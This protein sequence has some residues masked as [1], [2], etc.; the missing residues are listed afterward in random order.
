MMEDYI[1]FSSSMMLLPMS[2]LGTHGYDA[3]RQQ[4]PFDTISVLSYLKSPLRRPTVIE[5]WAPLEIATFEAAM[6]EYGKE[7]P[8]VQKEVATKSMQEVVEFYY[9]WKKTSHYKS[10]KKTYIPP[11]DDVSDEE[12]A[13]KKDGKK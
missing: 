1:E 11:H 2:K 5:K 10:W 8:K 6:C 9:V 7:F 3:S 4:Y 13:S 12:L